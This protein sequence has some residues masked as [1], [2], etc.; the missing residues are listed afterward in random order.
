MRDTNKRIEL[1]RI[2]KMPAIL[3]THRTK[4]DPQSAR[5]TSEKQREER[6]IPKVLE[7]LKKQSN[8]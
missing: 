8:E 5:N 3:T 4:G 6:R 7:I 1:K 2:L